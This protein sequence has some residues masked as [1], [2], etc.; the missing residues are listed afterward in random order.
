MFLL[1]IMWIGRHYYF[2]VFNVVL[3]LDVVVPVH[4]AVTSAVTF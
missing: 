4:I 1:F 2:Y 3:K